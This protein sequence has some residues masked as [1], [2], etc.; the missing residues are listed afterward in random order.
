MLHFF[1][2]SCASSSEIIKQARLLKLTA[3]GHV[4]L[5]SSE[6]ETIKQATLLTLWKHTLVPSFFGVWNYQTSYVI[7][8]VGAGPC[9][10]SFFGVWNYQ[11]KPLIQVVGIGP[12]CTSFK[13]RAPP[14]LKLSNKP[15]YW[16][17]RHWAMLHFSLGWGICQRLKFI[18]PSTCTKPVADTVV[19][20]YTLSILDLSVTTLLYLT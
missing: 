18:K 19:T 10:I 5:L 2:G 15:H 3:L 20:L 4:T 16:S 13:D 8:A 14:R 7:E 1:L 6:S 11:N 17:C 9:Y 12:C